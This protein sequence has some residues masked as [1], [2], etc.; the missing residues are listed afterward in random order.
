MPQFTMMVTIES[1]RNQELEATVICSIEGRDRPATRVDPP[2]YS[3]VVVDSILATPDEC[4]E[5]EYD[6]SDF[7]EAEW[8]RIELAADKYMSELGSEQDDG[9]YEVE[10]PE[11]F[12]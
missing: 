12:D 8:K 6:E 7:S 4:S 1:R 10:G 5:Q 11:D 9:Y 2:E 3:Y